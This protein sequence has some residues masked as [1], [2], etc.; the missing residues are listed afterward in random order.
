MKVALF[1]LI[2]QRYHKA[3]EADSY[4]NV[5]P[6]HNL[7]F[8]H[9]EK[10]QT[11]ELLGRRGH[12]FLFHPECFSHSAPAVS[13]GSQSQQDGGVWSLSVFLFL[14]HNE[15]PHME[16]ETE[17]SSFFFDPVRRERDVIFLFHICRCRVVEFASVMPSLGS[18]LL[19]YA[20]GSL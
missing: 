20:I 17:L 19:P 5:S 14:F 13:F 1:N 18:S 4:T 16:I 12:I 6:H 2:Y 9:G 8:P 7:C 3:N 10:V 11:E 15:N